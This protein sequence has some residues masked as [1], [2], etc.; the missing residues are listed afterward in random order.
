MVTHQRTVG[1][2]RSRATAFYR[3]Q[4]SPMF[5]SRVLAPLFSPPSL[6]RSSLPSSSFSSVSVFNLSVFCCSLCFFMLMTQNT[7]NTGGQLRTEGDLGLAFLAACFVASDAPTPPPPLS[8]CYILLVTPSISSFLHL[9]H[10]HTPSSSP[11]LTAG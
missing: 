8:I 5:L 4:L 3:L 7:S 1:D 6:Q 10:C 9:F 2:C 11:Y